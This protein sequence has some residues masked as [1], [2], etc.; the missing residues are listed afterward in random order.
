MSDNEID[1]V[2]ATQALTNT[3][4]NTLNRS[5]K[6]ISDEIY[7]V[8]SNPEHQK[9]FIKRFVKMD[10][11]LILLEAI[12]IC[13]G[14]DKKYVDYARS[15]KDY[16]KIKELVQSLV[17]N[18]LDIIDHHLSIKEWKVKPKDFVRWLSDNDQFVIDELCIHF[19]SEEDSSLKPKNQAVSYAQS[20]R[21]AVKRE[22]VLMAAI[23]ILANFPDQCIGRGNKVS[24][25]EI[26]RVMEEKSPLWFGEEQ[27]PLKPKPLKELISKALKI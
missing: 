22:K 9:A 8:R 17:A 25:T 2:Q 7:Q 14:Y 12:P 20:E 27:I 18:D 1:F 15:D 4:G 21:H 24:A 19:L 11:W 3:L 13:L 26:A 6:K 10:T 5:N 23:S 16:L